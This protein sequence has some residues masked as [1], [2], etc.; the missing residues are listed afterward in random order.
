MVYLFY[1]Y[2]FRIAQGPTLDELNSVIEIIL[3]N[4]QEIPKNSQQANAYLASLLFKYSQHAVLFEAI[5]L[6]I[7]TNSDSPLVVQST[8][9]LSR[10]ISAKETNL[11]YLG[12]DAL[13]HL[14]AC[15]DSLEVLKENFETIVVSLSDRD[16]SVRRRALDLLYSMADRSNY[17]SIIKELLHY[18][19]LSEFAIREELVLKIAIMTEKFFSD[20]TWY[21][22]TMLELIIG[23]GD[24]ISDD[25]WHR[26]VQIISN[27]ELIH[28]YVARRALD[29]IKEKDGHENFVKIA[30]YF[31]GEY[32]HLIA[33]EDES[34]PIHQLR[35]IEPR[36][37]TANISTRY[38]FVI[39]FG[40]A[41]IL[42]T[43]LKFINVFP[44]IKNRIIRILDSYRS[45]LDVELQQRA[46]EYHA[47]AVMASPEI[48]ETVCDAIP[49]FSQRGSAL[50]QRLQNKLTD[51][52][53]K[54]Y[55]MGEFMR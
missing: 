12:L 44:E 32:G 20:T 14:A 22:D 43:L 49:P 47:I 37:L 7:H 10:F 30:A 35:S 33:E 18:L 9:L 52:E 21:F 50:L 13:A 11:R 27:D 34:N 16:I 42:T 15:S 8:I 36:L 4:S 45:V 39:L 55:L 6:A 54:R 24:A 5:N 29:S 25:V 3:K 31:L 2:S 17:Q 51:T 1:S 41:V 40:R 19:T 48:L 53:D 26:V 28:A 23:S 38:Y 46:C